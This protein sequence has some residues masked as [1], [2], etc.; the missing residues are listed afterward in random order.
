MTRKSQKEETQPA[1]QKR[2][3]RRR[4]EARPAEIVEAGLLEF[5][6]K[7]FAAARLEDVA[8]RAGI[9][10]GTIYRYFESKEA[11]FEAA[12]LSRVTP[13]LDGVEAAVDAFPG[14]SEDLLRLLL[15]R[16]YEDMVG[17]DLHVLLRV[18]IAD[19]ARFPTISEAYYRRI[20][21][22]GRSLLRRIVERGIARGEFRS[23]AV[24]DLPMVVVAP[25]L[26][27]AIWRM[28]FA[29][30]ESIP[31]ERFLAAHLDLALHG[32]LERAPRGG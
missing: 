8:A 22:K 23:G 7:G 12:L 25:A 4:K 20:L 26:M 30:Y 13:M 32:L 1:D 21:S 11:L 27:A 10:K 14:S 17:S 28:T 18:I 19:G 9:A 24:A 31:P 3:R 16:I 15:T 2:P 5:S 29:R 6:E